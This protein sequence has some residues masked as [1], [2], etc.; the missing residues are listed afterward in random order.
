[1]IYFRYMK[2][3]GGDYVNQ[4]E[5]LIIAAPYIHQV[6]RGEAIVAVADKKSN[7]IVKYF[8]GRNVDSGYID[9]QTVNPQD[10]N[11]H[12]AFSGRNADVYIDKSVYG[13]AINAFAFPVREGHEVVGAL[14]I[15]LP[16]EREEKIQG[17]LEQI[18][19]IVTNLQ[20]N[21]HT[22]ASHSEELAATSEEVAS[23]AEHALENSA[24]TNT[25]TG[26]IKDVSRQTNLLGLNASIEAARAGQYGA[27]FNIVA[28][29][30][31][32]LSEQTAQSTIQI[33]TVIH[34]VQQDLTRLKENITQIS[35]ASEEEAQLVQNFSH[36]IEDLHRLNHELTAFFKESAVI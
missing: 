5:A 35:T 8:S 20:D 32:N 30:V 10:N 1:M 31:R 34:R 19:N 17:Y 29:E 9:G 7:S 23:Q 14:A 36:V 12:T 18:S 15:G 4:I 25:I 16:V 26:M 24:Q 11:V 2:V 3:N 22:I 13:V 27:G 28:Q 33:E 6:L 21:V